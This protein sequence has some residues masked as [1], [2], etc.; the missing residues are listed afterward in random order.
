[1]SAES[2]TSARIRFGT[3]KATVNALISPSTPKARR[4]MISRTRPRMRE[5]PVTSEKIAVDHARRRRRGGSSNVLCLGL[6]A[7]AARIGQRPERAACCYDCRRP[8]RGPFSRVCRTSSNRSAA[9]R[10][11]PASGSRTCA[12]ARPRRRS[13]S[14][15]RRRSPTA[16][17]EAASAA[18]RELVRC[19]DR[20]AA[21]RAIHPNRAARKKSQAARL[22]AGPQS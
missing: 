22:V 12:T 17:Q 19:L 3:W 21:R 2:A 9:S 7:H 20:A 18:H 8:E 10:S 4:A 1:M 13:T 16:T 14:G 15:S 11:P 5:I 6:R